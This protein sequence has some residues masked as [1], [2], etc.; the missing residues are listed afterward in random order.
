MASSAGKGKSGLPQFQQTTIIPASLC[1]VAGL[2]NC[3]YFRYS[4]RHTALSS[5]QII[6][7]RLKWSALCAVGLFSSRTGS[8]VAAPVTLSLKR[9]TKTVSMGD[10]AHTILKINGKWTIVKQHLLYFS[11]RRNLVLHWP[12]IT[13]RTDHNHY[14]AATS[15]LWALCFYE[16]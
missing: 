4:V 3:S 16:A 6:T 9:W 14:D 12:T 1:S 13:T 2:L 15:S 5:G 8:N 10:T 11:A 7:K